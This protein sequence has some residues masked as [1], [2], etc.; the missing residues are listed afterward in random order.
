MSR[1]V[2]IVYDY[3][4]DDPLLLT[5]VCGGGDA[6]R[7][8][9]LSRILAITTPKPLPQ[10]SVRFCSLFSLLRKR[11]QWAEPLLPSGQ[12]RKIREVF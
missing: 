6:I 5:I 3:E 2:Y 4:G 1:D 7:Y 11:G 10:H 8:A 12:L 9:P